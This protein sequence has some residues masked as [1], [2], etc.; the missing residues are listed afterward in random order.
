MM[1]DNSTSRRKFLAVYVGAKVP[2]WQLHSQQVSF[3]SKSDMREL[4]P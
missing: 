1:F 2:L 4:P 3:G